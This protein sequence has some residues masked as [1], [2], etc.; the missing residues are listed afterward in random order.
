[1]PEISLAT[2]ARVELAAGAIER[3]DRV[4]AV[5]VLLAIPLAERVAAAAWMRALG[6]D[7]P[8]LLTPTIR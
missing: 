3:G 5:G 8:G 7:L 1:M 4:L 6:V 2:A